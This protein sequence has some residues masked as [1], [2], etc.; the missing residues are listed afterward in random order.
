MLNGTHITSKPNMK[1]LGI[2]F[3]SKLQWHNQVANTINKSRSALHSIK[4]IRKYFTKEETLKLLTSNFYSIL[5]YNSE[6]W[7]TPS[8]NVKLKQ[9]ILSASANALKICTH[10]TTDSCHLTNYILSITAQHQHK[11]LNINSPLPC[12]PSSI[13]KNPF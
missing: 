4:I 1:V 12:S 8:L 6:I 9:N 3:D 5:Y 7:N 10:H 2:T 13:H 11:C